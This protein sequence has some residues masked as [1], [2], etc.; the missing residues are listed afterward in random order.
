MGKNKNRE[1]I[2][3]PSQKRQDIYASAGSQQQL[4]P[5]P[6]EGQQQGFTNSFAN[7]YNQASARQNQDYGDIMGSYNQ[8]RTGL[9]PLM[10]KPGIS[11][12]RS[13]ETQAAMTG[14]QGF[15]DTGGY[16]PQDIQELRARGMSPIRA[17]YGN[18]MREMDRSRGLGG[19]YAPNYIAAASKAQREMPGQM[20]DAATGVNAELANSI[21]QGKLSGLAGLGGLAGDEASRDL[22]AQE[23]NSSRDLGLQGLNLSGIQ[24]ASGL[25]G[26]SPGMAG[27]YG[28][29]LLNSTGQQG[30][31]LSDRNK[32]NIGLM[33]TQTDALGQ[34]APKGTPWWKSALGYAGKV[35]LAVAPYAAMAMSSRELKE[36]IK[37]INKNFGK[38]LKELPLYT[39]KYKGDDVKHMGP[40]AEEFKSK[41][42]IGDGKTLHLAD[43]MGVVLAS[44][45]EEL[46]A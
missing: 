43:V 6:L 14:Y 41:F 39:W 37:P 7:N 17:A 22:S 32:T 34:A 16:T 13:P 23:A 33:G 19:G 4:S 12:S 21:R 25:F 24:G 11:L 8:F 28:N 27:T 35:G 40:M 5:G 26:T 9:Q 30:G 44:Q 10:D 20:A 1:V 29:Q 3:D 42:G 36:D 15:A 45:K 18:T 31:L 2:G 46:N 38:K